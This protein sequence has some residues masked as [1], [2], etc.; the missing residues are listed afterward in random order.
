[1]PNRN[2]IELPAGA[3]ALL[4]D[5]LEAMAAGRGVTIIPENAEL[6]TVEAA[7]ALNV[8][9]P[10]LIKLLDDG[11]IPHRKVGKHRRIRMEDVV[12][13]KARDDREREAILDQLV[14]EAQEQDMDY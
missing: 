10:Y 4:M 12:A 7:S 11:I 13:Y 5:I 2:P 14:G 9:R 8:S 3:A 6:T 1:M